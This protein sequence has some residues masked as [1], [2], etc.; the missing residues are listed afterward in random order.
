MSLTRSTAAPAPAPDADAQVGIAA[1]LIYAAGEAAV[2]AVAETAVG[3]FIVEEVGAA[4][5]F[6]GRAIQGGITSCLVGIIA[7]CAAGVA[8]GIAGI[9]G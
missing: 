9:A 1:G 2:E 8:H 7:S 4:E 3:D 6:A 5:T